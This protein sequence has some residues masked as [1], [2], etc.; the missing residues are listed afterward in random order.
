MKSQKL[1]VFVLSGDFSGADATPLEL[2]SVR[3][4]GQA[5]TLRG[6]GS[7]VLRGHPP[8]TG[9]HKLPYGA[10]AFPALRLGLAGVL[11]RRLGGDGGGLGVAAFVRGGLVLERCL[12]R[13]F[14]GR[15]G[16][17]GPALL[18]GGFLLLLLALAVA[19]LGGVGAVGVVVVVLVVVVVTIAFPLSSVG[20][21]K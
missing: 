19:R 11:V 14:L 1:P 6:G 3:R 16:R 10:D 17:G 21:P 18:A 7:Q 2:K 20:A 15:S 4:R 12:V 13:R 9:R 8:A 5:D